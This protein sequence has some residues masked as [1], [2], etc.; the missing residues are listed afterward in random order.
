MKRKS[1]QGDHQGASQSAL[2]D[3]GLL[4]CSA[5][6]VIAGLFIFLWLTK[7]RIGLA[8]YFMGGM[9]L[10]FLLAVGQYYKAH[11]RSRLFLLF[12]LSWMIVH[13]VVTALSIAYLHWGYWFLT[14]VI[15]LWVGNS[16][17]ARIFGPP[18]ADV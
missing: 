17:A 1:E 16:I 11:L 12:L 13:L 15:E 14:L 18:S 2:R 7:E 8:G 5:L 9:G 4:I 6:L 3:A 10:V